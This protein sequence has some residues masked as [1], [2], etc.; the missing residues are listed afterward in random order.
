MTAVD[1]P[2]NKAPTL[3]DEAEDVG[4]SAGGDPTVGVEKTVKANF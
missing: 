1:S 3:R 2:A 4:D